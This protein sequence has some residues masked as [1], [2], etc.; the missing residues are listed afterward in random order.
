MLRTETE[1]NSSSRETEVASATV[2]ADRCP[3]YAWT[4]LHVGL[5]PC[6]FLGPHGRWVA[7]E[8]S[9]RLVTHGK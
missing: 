2:D 7:A 5:E 1:R 8:R 6:T 3:A 4:I 9:W